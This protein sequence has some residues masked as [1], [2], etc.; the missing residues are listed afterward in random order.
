MI[1]NKPNKSNQNEVGGKIS[2]KLYFSFP[3]RLKDCDGIQINGNVIIKNKATPIRI[4]FSSVRYIITITTRD[5]SKKIKNKSNLMNANK[6]IT[7][8]TEKRYLINQNRKWCQF[9]KDYTDIKS[10]NKINI[11]TE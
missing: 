5:L 9:P 7:C 8:V 3:R 10:Q 6:L 4:G 11:D 1:V 2:G